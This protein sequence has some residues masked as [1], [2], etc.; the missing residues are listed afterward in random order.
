MS[1]FKKK[2]VRI[3]KKGESKKCEEQE[4]VVNYIQD[5]LKFKENGIGGSNEPILET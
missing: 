1:K 2:E 5:V 4:K 3:C